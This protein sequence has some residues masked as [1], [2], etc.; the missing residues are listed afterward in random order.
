M[1]WK[2]QLSLW[3]ECDTGT[4]GRCGAEGVSA[5]TSLLCPAFFLL[6]DQRVF[7]KCISSPPDCQPAPVPFSDVAQKAAGSRAELPS[8]PWLGPPGTGR[9]SSACCTRQGS[10]GYGI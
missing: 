9:H 7:T 8:E 3:S 4:K 2:P 10:E 5:Q 6:W 1:S